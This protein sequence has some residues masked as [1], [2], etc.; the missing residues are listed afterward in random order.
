MEFHK[1][2]VFFSLTLNFFFFFLATR[3]LPLVVVSRGHS[4]VA[5]HRLLL[6]VGSLVVEHRLW[7]IPAS[8]AAA[9]GLSGFGLWVLGSQASAVV[10]HGLRCSEAC[11]I[12]P[13]QGLNLCPLHCRQI[14]NTGPPGSPLTSFLSYTLLMV[15]FFITLSSIYQLSIYV[16]FN[17][18]QRDT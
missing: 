2:H 3:R 5:M 12:S 17:V 14:L 4:L 10:V 6:A 15:L 7:S 8:V 16:Y 9:P 13:D 1:L 11:G 18:E